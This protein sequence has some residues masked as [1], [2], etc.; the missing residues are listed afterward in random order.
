M[1]APAATSL[2]DLVEQLG[3]QL[4]AGTLSADTAVQWVFEFSDGGLTRL[5][6]ASVLERARFLR[7][8]LEK[9]FADASAL[10]ERIEDGAA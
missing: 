6:A 7:A 4:A 1:N 2:C 9:A 5:G 8:E 3:P 10:L